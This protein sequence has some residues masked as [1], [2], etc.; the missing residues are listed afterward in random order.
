MEKYGCLGRDD[1]RFWLPGPVKNLDH[2]FLS[3]LRLWAYLLQEPEELRDLEDSGYLDHWPQTFLGLRTVE[4][5][6]TRLGVALLKHKLDRLREL[7]AE[8]AQGPLAA[9]RIAET[10]CLAGNL[11]VMSALQAAVENEQ[12]FEL[13]KQSERAA[14]ARAS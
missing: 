7:D 1:V 14:R 10:E 2:R 5:A 8:H 4:Q 9:V 11:K 12:T 13:L 3:C 6:A